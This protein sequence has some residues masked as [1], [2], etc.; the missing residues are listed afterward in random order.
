MTK[1]TRRSILA[2]LAAS[3]IFAGATR[4]DGETRTLSVAGS[5]RTLSLYIHGAVILDFQPNGIVF[6]APKVTMSG[7]IVHAYRIGYGKK[8]EGDEV[9]PGAPLALLGFVGQTNPP[10]VPP[11]SIPLLGPRKLDASGNYCSLV[12]PFPTTLTPLRQIPKDT[13][14]GDFFPYNP[15]LSGLQYLSTVLRADFSIPADGVTVAQLVGGEWKDNRTDPLA[16]H[17]RAEPGNDAYAD[18]DAFLAIS[19]TLTTPVQLAKGYSKAAA[20]YNA[21]LEQR[22]LLEVSHNDTGGGTTVAPCTKEGTAK[23]QMHLLASRPA[24]CVSFAVNNTG[25]KLS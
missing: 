6:H 10:A 16:I 11:A 3:P 7:A 20:K 19:T 18:H 4:S 23:D 17:L 24:N 25:V 8:G 13:S 1:L 21:D 2:G 15:E 12:T 14:C 22:T 5:T 9:Y